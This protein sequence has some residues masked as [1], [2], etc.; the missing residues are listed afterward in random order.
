MLLKSM[1]GEDGVEAAPRIGA[2]GVAVVAA[3]VDDSRTSGANGGA[4]ARCY[5][6]GSR[7]CCPSCAHTERELMS[8]CEGEPALVI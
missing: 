4:A 2:G 7:S 3:H 6:A 5:L 1:G 8:S